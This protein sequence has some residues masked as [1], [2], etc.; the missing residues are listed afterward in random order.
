MRKQEPGTWDDFPHNLSVACGV[1]P[2]S[3]SQWPS[4]GS[5]E[6]TTFCLALLSLLNR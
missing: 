6:K 5:L 3:S 1:G 4:Q 2:D